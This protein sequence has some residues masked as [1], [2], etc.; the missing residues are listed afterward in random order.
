MVR[1]LDPLNWHAILNEAQRA[2]KKCLWDDAATS[3]SR[4][5]KIDPHNSLAL[6]N[7][8]RCFAHMQ[9]FEEALR[10]ICIAIQQDPSKAEFYLYRGCL[11]RNKNSRKALEDL[12]ISILLDHKDHCGA[13]SYFQRAMLYCS[14]AKFHLAVS[15]YRSAIEIDPT[16][17]DSHLNLGLVYMKHLC[18]Y[19]EALECFTK[20][21]RLGIDFQVI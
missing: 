1:H 7:R 16:H 9:K 3:Y 6:A 5:L 8:G 15:D 2:F 18:E 21:I 19:N 14:L 10:D 4:L 11:L 20:A 13:E 12:S 17:C